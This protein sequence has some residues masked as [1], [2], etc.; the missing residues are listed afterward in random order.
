MA[1]IIVG[2]DRDRNKSFLDC[3][4]IPNHPEVAAE[5]PGRRR[6]V[7]ETVGYQAQEK[8]AEVAVHRRVREALPY[9]RA[10]RP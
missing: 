6:P 8:R 2:A 7:P 1:H 10:G 9:R 5:R 3:G 4:E